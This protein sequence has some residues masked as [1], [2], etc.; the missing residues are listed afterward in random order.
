VSGC[1]LWNAIPFAQTEMSLSSLGLVGSK[2]DELI[3]TGLTL[4]EKSHALKL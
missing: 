3:M 1:C 2:E 4:D